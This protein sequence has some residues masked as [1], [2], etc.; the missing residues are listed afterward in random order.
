MH[1]ALTDLSLSHDHSFVANNPAAENAR[2]ASTDVG[3]MVN[4]ALNNCY[5]LVG[6][7]PVASSSSFPA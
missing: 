5:N 7:F 2:S 1:S 4:M 6:L 3:G